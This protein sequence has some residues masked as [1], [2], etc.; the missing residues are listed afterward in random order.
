LSIFVSEFP[1]IRACGVG[2]SFGGK[3]SHVSKNRDIWPVLSQ[4]GAAI[5]IDLTEGDGSHSGPFEADGKS[6]DA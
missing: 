3:L 4:D 1:G 2:Q 5:G 6:A